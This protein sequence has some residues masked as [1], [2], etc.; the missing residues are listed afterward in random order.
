ML[1]EVDPEG[2]EARRSGTLRRRAYTNQGPNYLIHLDG[3][4]KLKRFGLC[5]HGCIDGQVF[6]LYYTFE[7]SLIFV[8]V[9]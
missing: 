3:Y 8:F 4:D 2:V 6:F 7:L 9:M 5:V 1:L